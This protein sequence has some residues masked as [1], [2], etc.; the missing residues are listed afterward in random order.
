MMFD[1]SNLSFAGFFRKHNL[2]IIKCFAKTASEMQVVSFFQL[3]Y[4][5]KKNV[6]LGISDSCFVYYVVV[7]VKRSSRMSSSSSI[8]NTTTTDNIPYDIR[9][10]NRNFDNGILQLQFNPQLITLLISCERTRN[11]SQSET[12]LAKATFNVWLAITVG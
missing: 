4:F 10:V 5:Y 2:I 3:F 1:F 8:H 11:D 6:L 7:N 12:H 9:I